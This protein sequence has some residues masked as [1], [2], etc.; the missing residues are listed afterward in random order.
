MGPKFA[1]KI[2]VAPGRVQLQAL[3]NWVMNLVAE[4]S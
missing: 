4:H 2:Y 1:V 3:V